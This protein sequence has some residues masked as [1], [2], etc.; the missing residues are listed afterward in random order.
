MIFFST[1]EHSSY[2]LQTYHLYM[3]SLKRIL[4]IGSSFILTPTPSCGLVACSVFCEPGGPWWCLSAPQDPRVAAV[5]H[6]GWGNLSLDLTSRP[7]DCR[8]HQ[9]WQHEAEGPGFQGQCEGPV[10]SRNELLEP[11]LDGQQRWVSSSPQA[12]AG[13]MR[14]GHE[15]FH[16]VMKSGGL[17]WGNGRWTD[18]NWCAYLQGSGVSQVHHNSKNLDKAEKKRRKLWEMAASIKEA[19]TSHSRDTPLDWN[20]STFQLR[21]SWC[22]RVHNFYIFDQQ[23]RLTN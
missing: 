13:T 23:P 3:C 15:C 6:G 12:L 16:S 11:S 10:E 1:L 7:R 18:L 17:V 14:T 2:S 22:S 8:A 21:L 5:Q 4:W 20:A 9:N 19:L